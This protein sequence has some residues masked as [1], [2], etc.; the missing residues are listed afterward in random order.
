[1]KLPNDNAKRKTLYTERIGIKLLSVFLSLLALFTIYYSLFTIPVHANRGSISIDSWTDAVHGLNYN[2]ES[3]DDKAYNNILT[4]IVVGIIGCQPTP[5]TPCPPL[6]EKGAAGATAD[7]IASI[8]EN[9]PASGIVYFADLLNNIG[10]STPAYAQEGV[11]F[12]F[13]SPLLGL[14]KAFRNIAYLGFVVVFV[15]TGFAIM[16]RTKLSPQAV[17]TVQS[18]LPRLVVALLLITFSYAIAGLLIDLSYVLFFLLTSS[19]GNFGG[20]TG[21]QAQMMQNDYL[22]AGF[23]ETIKVILING[24]G[25]LK[26]ILGGIIP[27][28]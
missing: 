5:T 28:L 9:P 3:F 21:E 20:I 23:F 26:D 6:E 12:G 25:A 14:W 15:A 24:A 8:Y 4:S 16:F 17:L 10:I 19:L 22:N 13:L 1:M 18:A 11:G 7:L 27:I 2:K